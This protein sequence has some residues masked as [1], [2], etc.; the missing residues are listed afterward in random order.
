MDT[1]SL[2]QIRHIVAEATG[3]VEGRLRDRIDEAQRHAGVLIED[4]QHK[5]ELVIE[6]QQALQQSLGSMRAEVHQESQETRALLR[7][8]YQ[9]LHQ[10]VE[11]L[12]QRV[13]VIEDRLGLTT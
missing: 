7:L 11:S 6:G 2:A 12:E 9:Q 5:F 4:L 13:L 3:A 1:E 10:R 8:S